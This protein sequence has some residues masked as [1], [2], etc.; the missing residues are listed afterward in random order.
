MDPNDFYSIHFSVTLL[1]RTLDYVGLKKI[2]GN[3]TDILIHI[4]HQNLLQ[5]VK[6]KFI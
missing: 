1:V 4:Y 2:R 6:R 3:K 5:D